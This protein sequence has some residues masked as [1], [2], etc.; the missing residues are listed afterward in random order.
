MIQIDHFLKTHT[1]NWINDKYIIIMKIK[2]YNR[3]HHSQKFTIEAR[4]SLWLRDPFSKINT[5]KKQKNN[6]YNCMMYTYL[7]SDNVWYDIDIECPECHRHFNLPLNRL[8]V[9]QRRN[10]WF[11]VDLSKFIWLFD[12]RNF[13][14]RKTI[15]SLLYYNNMN[16]WRCRGKSTWR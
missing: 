6:Q 13:W 2:L 15:I 9:G 8:Y 7:G 10:A 5:K 11:F 3:I 16:I 14:P 12:S 4:S 1:R